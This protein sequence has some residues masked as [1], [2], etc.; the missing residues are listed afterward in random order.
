MNCSSP[1]LRVPAVLVIAIALVAC[2]GSGKNRMDADADVEDTAVDT[3]M[4]IPA[5]T[6][7][8]TV[9][10]TVGDP[11][12]IEDPAPDLVDDPTPDPGEDPAPD[13]EEDLAPDPADDSTT[14]PIDDPVPDPTVDT[15]PDTTVDTSPDTTTCPDDSYEDNDTDTTP[16]TGI[17]TGSYTSLRVCP[18]DDDYYAVTVSPGDAIT[19]ALLFG[20]AEG[21]V[22][23]EIIDATGTTVAY[24][25][26]VTDD[27]WAT[28][29]S[30]TGGTYLVY[31][32]LYSDAG[33]SIGN[34]YDMDVT[35]GAPP[36]CTEDTYEDNDTDTAASVIAAGTI[37]S[38]RICPGDDDYYTARVLSG[39]T[40]TVDVLFLHADGDIDVELIDS[41]GATADGSYTLTDNE[42]VTDTA[43]S[44]GAY[45]IY[46]YLYADDGSTLGNDYSI[47]LSIS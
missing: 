15:S 22:D 26:S 47:D 36:V 7:P 10:D 42:T 30:T 9:L 34:D 8:E 40:I 25:D 14:D 12:A 6:A 21:D 46:I 24:S 44:D 19:V 13:L 33:T 32:Y 39:Q 2:G 35:V 23:L 20:D 28:F 1:A 18:S 38:L 17:T 29:T 16:S 31:V 5:D 3:G 11:D 37:P 27:E 41:T 43:T 4:D 45:I